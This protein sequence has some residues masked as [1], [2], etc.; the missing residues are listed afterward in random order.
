MAFNVHE[1]KS[2]KKYYMISYHYHNSW[3]QATW[4]KQ[5]FNQMVVRIGTI[6]KHKYVNDLLNY[7]PIRYWVMET[8]KMKK[9]WSLKIN[10]KVIIQAMKC[11]L[12]MVS[13]KGLI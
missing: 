5:L 13:N 2:W 10:K 11:I 1:M 12:H 9:M 4:L 8:K 3:L 7:L 6:G